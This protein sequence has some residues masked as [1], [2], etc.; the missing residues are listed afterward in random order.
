MENTQISNLFGF[1]HSAFNNLLHLTIID[2]LK[3]N[4]R[5]KKCI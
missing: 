1:K 2:L 5:K 4:E 3:V